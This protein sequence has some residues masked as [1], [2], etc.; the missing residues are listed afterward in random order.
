MKVEV[1]KQPDSTS[2][3]RIE[4]P[5]EEVSKEWDA[6][7][8]SFARFAKIPGYRPG[9]APRKVIEAKFKK[10][11]QD[12]LT[13]KL[14]S[15]SYR[16]AIEQKQLRV[17]SLTNVEDVKLGEDKSLRFRA[18]VVTAPEFELPEYKNIPVQL[19]STGVAEA[20]VDLALERLR[21]QSA[22]FVDVPERGVEMEDFVVIDFE[23]TVDGKPI[24]EVAPQASKTLHGG[25]KFWLRVAPG[26][27]LPN[28]CEQLLGQKPGETRLVIVDLAQDFPVKELTG[29][30]ATYAVTLDE[31]KQKI[32]PAVDEALAEK[33]LPGK[34]L[35][36]LR[37][38]IEHDLAHEKE[39]EVER[40]KEGQIVKYLQE[41]VQFDLPPVLLRNETRRALG[42][43]VQRN[44]QRGVTDEM[45][46]EKEK[47][48]VEGAG[49]LAAHRLKTN[50]ILHR[51]A[52][53]EKIEVTRE[54]LRD[55]I[56]EEAAR[57][58]VS[59]EK[60]RK[61]LEERD[62]LDGFAEQILLGKT[63]DFLKANVSVQPSVEPTVSEQKT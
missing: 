60:M 29:Q 51:I 63:L 43:L 38:T 46:K 44:R 27:F 15:K 8:N 58:D 54:E 47:E 2:T 33:L 22:D 7:A 13:K 30:K 1:E 57:Y 23:G 55:Q 35:A 21:D 36:D 9:K 31:L 61:E 32:L 11:I 50:F 42:E 56:R 5:P 53:R 25:K 6:I 40:A 41:K 37:H 62:G 28:F 49:G 18:T 52:E 4:L 26:N 20:D 59:P 14:V 34:T 24:S 19:P 39:H 12:E 45:L 16:D 3:L 17:V 48:L 10:E